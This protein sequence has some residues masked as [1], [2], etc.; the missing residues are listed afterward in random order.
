MN[1]INIRVADCSREDLTDYSDSEL[2]L[3]VFNDEGLYRMRHRKGFDEVLDQ[4]F[5]YT[6]EQWQELITDLEEDL[7]EDN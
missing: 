2:S 1:A 3:R 4:I 5:V 7:N 6:P